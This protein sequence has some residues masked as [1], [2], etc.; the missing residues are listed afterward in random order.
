MAV[1]KRKV[2]KARRDKRRSSHWKLDM[3]GMVKCPHCGEY[4][5]SHR[6]CKACG[7]YNGKQVKVVSE[8]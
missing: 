7:Y 6:V 2:S 8:D 3:P 5:L 1:P 4:V